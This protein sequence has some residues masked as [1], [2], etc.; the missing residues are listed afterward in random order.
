MN[1]G[2]TSLN[3]CFKGMPLAM[4]LSLEGW[5]QRWKQRGC[6]G[7][8]RHD[9]G[10]TRGAEKPRDLGGTAIKTTVFPHSLSMESR[11]TK[12]TKGTPNVWQDPL[13][14]WCGGWLIMT[15]AS[16]K[17]HIWEADQK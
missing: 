13:E 9:G 2:M 7:P 3:L 16:A 6:W 14:G 10:G 8:H 11:K 17:E 15:W 5:V 4:G 1:R 12:E